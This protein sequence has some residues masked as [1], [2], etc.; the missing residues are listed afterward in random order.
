[1]LALSPLSRKITFLCWLFPPR[2]GPYRAYAEEIRPYAGYYNYYGVRRNGFVVYDTRG[3]YVG[4]DP[5]PRIRST[6]AHDPSPN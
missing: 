6:L 1:M 5:D 3:R 4:S 2:L